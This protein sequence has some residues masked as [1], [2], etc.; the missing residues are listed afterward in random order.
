MNE[1]RGLTLIEVMVALAIT[2]IALMAASQAMRSLIHGAARQEQVVF[3][4]LCAENALVGVKLGREFPAIGQRHS[5]CEQAGQEFQVTMHVSG[6][7][8]PS[9]RRVQAQVLQ[10]GESV[11]SVTAL[12]GR[13]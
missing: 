5:V 9:F 13:Y 2:A 7:A 1:Q 4:Q 3:A 10:A 11:L 6:T 8:N 12:I